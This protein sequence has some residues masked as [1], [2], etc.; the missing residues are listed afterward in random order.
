MKEILRSYKF[1][2]YPNAEQKEQLAQTFGCARFVYNWALSNKKEAYENNIKKSANDVSKELTALKKDPN[3]I[4]L[5]DV[6][7]VCLQQSLMNLDNAY[8][9]FFK[10]QG[11]FPTY[12]K[13]SNKQSA[14]YVK[15]GFVFKNNQ[16]KLAKQAKYMKVKFSRPL[17]GEVSSITVSKTPEGKYYASL[18]VKE[19]YKPKSKTAKQLG[20]DLGIKD[21][22]TFSDGKRVANP[23]HLL[24]SM[25]KLKRLQRQLSRKVKGS[26]NRDKARIKVARLHSKIA[27]QRADFLHKL[28]TQIINENQVI[29]VETLSIKEMMKTRHIARLVGSLGLNQFL[30]ML[31][32]KSEWNEREFIQIDRWFPS[33]KTCF[34]CG[35]VNGELTLKDRHWKCACGAVIDRDVNAAKN[36]LKEGLLILHSR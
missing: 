25:K 19:H 4:W 13:R 28:S 6:S 1:R 34:E 3:F 29:C 31:R 2:I 8:Q 15:S 20:I 12:K 14:R 11:G 16:L 10:K 23:K 30:N 32:Y 24:S 35:T 22:A 21:F 9:R 27:N 7:S 33:S 17:T 18:L 26:K 5:K 36:I